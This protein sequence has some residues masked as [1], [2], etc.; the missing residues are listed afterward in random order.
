MDIENLG[1][2]LT[3]T[4]TKAVEWVTEN[5]EVAIGAVAGFVFGGGITGSAIGAGLGYLASQFFSASNP[6]TAAPA[7]AP[8][9]PKNDP[10]FTGPQ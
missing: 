10:R 1:E 3:N 2:T 7:T 6:S 8:V 9:I 5:P 4:F